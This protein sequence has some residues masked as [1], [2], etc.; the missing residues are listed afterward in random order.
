MDFQSDF[1]LISEKKNREDH[2]Q[3]RMRIGIENELGYIHDSIS[4]VTWA[5]AVT[6]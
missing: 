2:I 6:L 1:F 4:R 3:D 5:G